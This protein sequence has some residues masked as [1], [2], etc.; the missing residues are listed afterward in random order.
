M[1]TLLNKNILIS[2]AGIAGPTLAYFLKEYGFNPTVIERS[3]R[4]REGG[5]LIG[6]H[7]EIGSEVVKRMDLWPRFQ[8]EKYINRYYSFEDA[9]EKQIA[10]F[11]VSTFIGQTSIKR[12]DL[13]RMI[14]ERTKGDVEYVFGESLRALKEDEEGVEVVFERGG[15]RRFDLVVGADG[16]HSN[17]RALAFGNESRFKRFLGYYIAT[18]T[19]HDPAAED[20]VVRAYISPGKGVLLFGMKASNTVA[21][22]SFKNRDEFTS[23]RYD[24]D[25]KKRRLFEAFASEG[26]ELPRLLEAMKTASD[27]SFD[28]LSQIRMATWSKGRVVLIGDASYCPTSLSG[29]GASLS[30]AG[31]YILAGE[32]R[33]AGDD[34]QAAF[35]AYER[36]LRPFVEQKQENTAHTSSQLFSESAVGLWVRNQGLKLASLPWVSRLVIKKMTDGRLLHASFPLKEYGKM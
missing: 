36:E 34:Y 10:R 27:F 30:L 13:A 32:L 16:V 33:A 20:G 4:P 23:D 12:T 26:W 22:L 21:V 8:K 9:S 25:A 15:T 6:L 24:T 19:V 28:S 14:Y 5:F 11:D 17:V 1:M 35:Q 7:G 31:A 2:G 18:F 3:P 29:S